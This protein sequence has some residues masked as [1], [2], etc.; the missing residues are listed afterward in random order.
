MRN[1]AVT[2]ELLAAFNQACGMS[3]YP[4][5]LEPAVLILSLYVR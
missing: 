3:C 1:N 4:I 2:G 5:L